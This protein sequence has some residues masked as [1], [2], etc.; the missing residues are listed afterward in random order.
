[1]KKV[2]VEKGE[3]GEWPQRGTKGAKKNQPIPRKSFCVF[4]DFLRLMDWGER[5]WSQ[6]GAK[7][8]K[9]RRRRKLIFAFFI[10]LKP[11][12]ENRKST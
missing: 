2:R 1:L 10:D 4:C 3:K 8:A 7:G 5:H 6:R 9:S 11:H 12:R